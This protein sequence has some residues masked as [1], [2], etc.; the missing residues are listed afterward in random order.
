[1]YCYMLIIIHAFRYS[2]NKKPYS[3]QTIMHRDSRMRLPMLGQPS[4]SI[5]IVA[6]KAFRGSLPEVYCWKFLRWV[7]ISPKTP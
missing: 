3:I 5:A 2:R 6:G 1:V 7:A 4:L